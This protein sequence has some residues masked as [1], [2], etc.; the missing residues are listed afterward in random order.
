MAG[1]SACSSEV[2]LSMKIVETSGSGPENF[3][4]FTSFG[5]NS[6]QD[7]RDCVFGAAPRRNIIRVTVVSTQNKKSAP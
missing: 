3:K 1:V 4:E 2:D 7:E 5:A 6:A